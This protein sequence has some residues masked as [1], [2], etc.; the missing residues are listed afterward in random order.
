MR[1]GLG[2]DWSSFDSGII[3]SYVIPR[4][5]IE[6]PYLTSGLETQ[7]TTAAIDK[8]SL[9]RPFIYVVL[10][11]ALVYFFIGRNL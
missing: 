3:D 1:T 2:F 6:L 10:A 7:Q 4:R 5:D 8:Y 11:S 9:T